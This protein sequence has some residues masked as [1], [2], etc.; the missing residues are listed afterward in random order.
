MPSGAEFSYLSEIQDIEPLPNDMGRH[1]SIA[2]PWWRPRWRSLVCRCQAGI[3][4]ARSRHCLPPGHDMTMA[5]GAR[6]RLAS[7]TSVHWLGQAHLIPQAVC[8]TP[9]CPLG[10]SIRSVTRET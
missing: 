4:H 3:L 9:D 10:R 8:K 7:C 5:S 6:A 1:G 2:A